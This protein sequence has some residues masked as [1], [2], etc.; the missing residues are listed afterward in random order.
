MCDH[1]NKPSNHETIYSPFTRIHSPRNPPFLV[2]KPFSHSHQTTHTHFEQCH[3]CPKLSATLR[4]NG[5]PPPLHGSSNDTN[6]TGL[7]LAELP[8]RLPFSAGGGVGCHCWNV[9]THLSS[10]CYWTTDVGKAPRVEAYLSKGK[11][12][13]LGGI[14]QRRGRGAL[15]NMDALKN[16]YKI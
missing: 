11:G 9:Q 13:V 10:R 6:S 1:F 2:M 15:S 8:L 7:L 4:P 12:N 16:A 14:L 5:P 3:G